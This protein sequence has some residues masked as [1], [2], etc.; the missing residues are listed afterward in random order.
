MAAISNMRL[1][2]TNPQGLSP[3]ADIPLDAIPTPAAVVDATGAIL[4]T[5]ADWRNAH[6]NAISGANALEWCSAELC[7]TLLN[8]IERA[9]AGE[10]PRFSQDYGPDDLPRRITV[11]A[12]G[13]GAILIDQ[14]IVV[15]A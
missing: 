11:A 15:P 5:N 8:A 12:S 2:W 3:I 7:Q 14:E 1:K 13:P 4:A 10:I 9:I 6:P